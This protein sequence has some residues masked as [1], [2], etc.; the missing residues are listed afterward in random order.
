[1]LKENLS[2]Q[3]FGVTIILL[4]IILLN[5]NEKL[6]EVAYFWGLGGAS[7]AILTPDIGALG[8]PHFRFFQFFLSHCLIIAIV[9]YMTV[10][11]GLRPRKGSLKRVFIITNLYAIFV[12]L[13]NYILGTNYLFISRKPD[14]ASLLNLFGPWYIIGVEI[15][16]FILFFIVYLPFIIVNH[17]DSNSSK[18]NIDA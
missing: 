6:F 15:I 9:I 17:N 14:T 5:K 12:G 3:L 10:V 18:I 16:A 1:M 11:E 8:F 7:Q 2:L 13:I 4:L